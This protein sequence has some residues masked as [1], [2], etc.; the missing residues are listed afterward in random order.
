M[1][2]L[3]TSTR[4]PHRDR[5]R[6]AILAA[7]MLLVAGCSGTEPDGQNGVERSDFA[8]PVRLLVVDDPPLAAVIRRE[9]QARGTGELIVRDVSSAAL[10]ARDRLDADAV[11]YPSGLLGELVERRLIVPVPDHVLDSET[12][13]W[14]DVF[15]LLRLKEATWGDQIYGLPL[16]SP[17]FVLYYR[18]D[19]FHR[20]GT[21]PP[22]TWREYQQLLPQL[23]SHGAAKVG[24]SRQEGAIATDISG[25]EGPGEADPNGGAPDVPSA[26]F[27]TVEPLAAGWASQVL[28]A[29]A[30][31]Y[32]RHRS[33]YSTLFD[34]TTMRPL[35]DGP[36]FVQA[37]EDLV[38]AAEY[39][40]PEPWTVTPAEA[41]RLFSTSQAVMAISW[42]T[43]AD[44]GANGPQDAH[45]PLGSRDAAKADPVDSR[46][47]GVSVAFA[48]LPGSVEVYQFLDET[49]EERGPDEPQ[50][51]PL[52]A[53]AGRLGSVTREAPRSRNAFSVLAW[54]AGREWSGR[55]SPASGSTTLFRSTHLSA[56]GS[57]VSP[58]L[59]DESARTYAELVAATQTGTTWLISLR[60][61]G[62]CEYLAALD[63][64]VHQ[65]LRKEA[66]PA[67][68]LRAAAVAWEE[69]TDRLGR[70]R[71][72]AAYQ[73]SIGV[74]R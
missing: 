73:R 49:W 41:R 17:Q 10:A 14:Q 2:I 30:A 64:A 60:V 69:T 26:G 18:A 23:A 59:G 67:Q 27:S 34:F 6:R 65:A 5:V 31:P 35:I 33:Q 70:E 61:P 28:L 22:Q 9:W 29:R 56:P 74:A 54:L 42:P 21:S 38:A 57:W 32:A 62:R 47:S 36:P 15:R 66:E 7:G 19:V 13:A 39:G 58:S 45:T 52:L 24:E 55:I 44:D 46:Q 72:R 43:R 1:T 11:I 37:L 68:A 40:P 12:L 53:V 20:L 25:P 3:T 63:R 8:A 48:Q 71:Q 4:S 51:V 50:R 16:G